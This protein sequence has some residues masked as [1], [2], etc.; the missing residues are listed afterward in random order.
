M[1]EAKTGI[2]RLQAGQCRRSAANH[3]K[4]GRGGQGVSLQ[5]SGGAWPVPAW[6]SDFQ[7]FQN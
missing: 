3:E 4:L 6:I 7:N 5:V 2:E 1:T